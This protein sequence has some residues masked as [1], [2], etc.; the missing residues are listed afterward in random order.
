MALGGISVCRE[1]IVADLVHRSLARTGHRREGLCYFLI[2]VIPL[3]FVTFG[4]QQSPSFVTQR[5]TTGHPLG[6]YN[7]LVQKEAIM[8]T[9]R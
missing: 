7:G 4:Y 5:V 3:I 6:C 8:R 1:M 9:W 2:T